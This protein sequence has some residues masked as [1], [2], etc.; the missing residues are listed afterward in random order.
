MSNYTFTHKNKNINKNQKIK[1]QYNDISNSKVSILFILSYS[2]NKE[3][4]I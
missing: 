1:N 4:L 2:E 3:I